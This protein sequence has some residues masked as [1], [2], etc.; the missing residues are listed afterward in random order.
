MG[1]DAKHKL[2]IRD[3][4][5][6][7]IPIICSVIKAAFSEYKGI[8]KPPSSA[9]KKSPD[10]V[11]EELKSRYA[12][13]ALQEKQLVGSVFY[14]LKENSVYIDR[15]AVLPK[16]QKQGIATYLMNEV[17]ARALKMNAEFLSLSVRLVLEKQQAYYTRL[18]F[19]FDSYGTH[20]GFS[21][22]T[23]MTMRK[24]L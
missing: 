5:K 2:L 23:F 17:E 11:S 6:A 7:D 16:H 21:E 10:V 19:V 24:A 1:L 3:Y 9:E 12:L 18:G 20:A 4:K 22:P 14:Q 8:L 15:L 13:V